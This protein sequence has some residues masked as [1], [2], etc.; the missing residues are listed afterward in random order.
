M[1]LGR[2][3]WKF[4]I[5]LWLAQL[6]TALGVGVMIWASRPHHPDEHRP[7]PP[8]EI[9]PPPEWAGATALPPP[10]RAI[11]PP[12]MPLVAGS[13][14]SLIFAAWLAWYFAR[15]ISTLRRAFEDEAQGQLE[16]RIGATMGRRRDELTDLGQDF[17]RMAER[18]QS[19]VEGQRRLLH[20]VSHEIRSPL[21]RLQAATDL[22]QQQPERAPEFIDRLQRDT[23][24]IDSLVGE[25]LTLSRLD[26]GSE[27]LLRERFNLTELIEAL[28][29]DAR[30]E[31]EAKTCTIVTEL[32]NEMGV[33]GD[34]ELL[35][36]AFENV[37][38]NALRHA[39]AGSAVRLFGRVHDERIRIDI[40]DAGPG[41]A[42]SDLE[43]IFEAFYRA[44][45]ATPFEGYGLGLAITL[46]VMKRH[47][48][49]AKAQN[50][51]GGG[52]MLSLSLPAQASV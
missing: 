9:R 16:T 38:R 25:L 35:R 45:N 34:I 44:A 37:L 52:F 50:L 14:V 42:E 33:D 40:I 47:H 51:P 29:D 24:R 13:I 17:D 7:P 26:T 27:Q 2:L 49:A 12:L 6:V 23:R 30:L 11:L 5:F 20:D 36:R 43:A 39:P 1:K 46:Q 48:G 8:H 10:R 21:G 15:P 31:A 3:F 19:L 22:M 28:V 41:V 18:L 4:F 32:P